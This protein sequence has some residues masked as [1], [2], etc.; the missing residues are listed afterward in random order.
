MAIMGEASRED[1]SEILTRI[2]ENIELAIDEYNRGY[3]SKMK[4]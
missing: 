1:P 4:R 2:C 3:N